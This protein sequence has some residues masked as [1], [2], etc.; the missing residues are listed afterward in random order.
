MR[1]PEALS[2]IP[3]GWQVQIVESLTETPAGLR[4]TF[5]GGDTAVVSTTD[6]EPP[7]LR[8]AL[9]VSQ[10]YRH[11]QAILLDSDRRIVEYGT[12]QCLLCRG[13]SD[14]PQMAHVLNVD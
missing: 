11:P 8:L 1:P 7:I 2:R 14:H 6:P 13:M 5:V 10:L 9:E 12:F 3:G 4:V